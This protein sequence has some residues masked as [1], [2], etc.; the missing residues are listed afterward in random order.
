MYTYVY[1]YMYICVYLHMYICVYQY[2]Y[3]Y[4]KRVC[5]SECEWASKVCVWFGVCVCVCVRV[6][7]CVR[8]LVF[9]CVCVWFGVADYMCEQQ[10]C[11]VCV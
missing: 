4:A 3:V 11:D 9:P 1:L 7:L 6:R 8:S 5:V 10:K 2:R